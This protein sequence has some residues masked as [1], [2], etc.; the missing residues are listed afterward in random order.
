MR[1]IS[2]LYED[3]ILLHQGIRVPSLYARHIKIQRAKVLKNPT[4]R[5]TWKITSN[6]YRTFNIF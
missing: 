2:R 3:M 1:L 5:D 4:G 6:L